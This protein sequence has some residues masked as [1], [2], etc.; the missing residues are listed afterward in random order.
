MKK[1]LLL[2]ITIFL[3]IS[4]TI[5]TLNCTGKKEV[6]T[7]MA[8]IGFDA[9]DWRFITP[10]MLEGKLPN[11]KKLIDSGSSGTMATIKPV[12][13]P[14]IWTTIATGKTPPQHGIL[15]FFTG[16]SPNEGEKTPTTSNFRKTKAL[17]NIL[18]DND[19]PSGTIGW[20]VSHPAEK[21]KGYMISDRT[22]I[23]SF[24][25]SDKYSLSGTGKTYPP[26]TFDKIK[27][28]IID[29]DSVSDNEIFR[30]F[31]IE[32]GMDSSKLR[33]LKGIYAQTESYTAIA[34][35]MLSENEVNLFNIYYEGID[36]ACHL[37]IRYIPP[38]LPGVSDEDIRKYHNV[39][40]NV[41]IYFDG[42]LGRLVKA[43][44][45]DTTILLM[46]DHGFRYGAER[47]LF[48]S[49]QMET[50]YAEEWHSERAL[51]IV[52]GNSVK[53][54]YKFKNVSVYDI[55]PTILD[56]FNIP[57]G[58]DMK[59]R[60]LRELF[61]EEDNK[62]NIPRIATH[63]KPDWQDKYFLQSSSEESENK[64]IE[65]KLKSLGYLSATNDRSPYRTLG[66]YYQAEK[67]Y[68][69]AIE[70]YQGALEQDSKN[71]LNLYQLGQAYL[72]NGNPEKALEYLEKA[73]L[74]D[75]DLLEAR[76]ITARAYYE[77]G[78]TE[79]AL[80]IMD[81]GIRDFPKDPRFAN[82]KGSFLAKQGNYDE[83][84]KSF[85]ISLSIYEFQEQTQLNLLHCYFR[86]GRSDEAFTRLEKLKDKFSQS[87]KFLSSAS[88]IYYYSRKYDNSLELL[89]M[90]LLVTPNDNS[91]LMR[92]ASTLYEMFKT[93]E[94][95][96]ILKTILNN[97]PES[98]EANFKL[99]VNY[100]REKRFEEAKSKLEKT[101]ELKSDFL[102]AMT[103]MAMVLIS[104]EQYDSA[105]EYLDRA[106]KIDPANLKVLKLKKEL[107]QRIQ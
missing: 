45:E 88:D 59:G 4:A 100:A 52:S 41:Y 12:L 102:P 104:L 92:K 96:E 44:P 101:L 6:N 31:G 86:S 87:P 62:K 75:P 7:K 82:Y 36:T 22:S 18:S 5:L 46:S 40:S 51:L 81:E 83:A 50:P 9:A 3:A 90:A 77:T 55:T 47:P 56:R 69:K 84:A 70:M 13:S 35:K 39:I 71:T 37:F 67:N 16:S 58:K 27:N 63:D 48:S 28:L 57:L 74:N 10:L 68:E 89:N 73:S 98:Y 26:E 107:G 14:I 29:P 42:I 15:D 95:I 24:Y 38:A 105:S 91:I 1:I 99:G 72:E 43:L 79:K 85:E 32:N 78:N 93:K 20:L 66:A 64:I 23:L 11:F 61:L 21:I 76:I 49:A 54:N 2:S 25:S 19:I 34:E 17:W 8:I 94:S 97:N 30:I 60:A 103:Y 80:S 53:K 33:K 65:E 106:L